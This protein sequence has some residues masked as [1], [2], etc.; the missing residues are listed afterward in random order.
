NAWRSNTMQAMDSAA[1]V[2]DY[3]KTSTFPSIYAANPV[4]TGVAMTTNAFNSPN[5]DSGNHLF[6]TDFRNNAIEVF[7]NQWQDISPGVVQSPNQAFTF[8]TPSTV[9][10]LHPFN[11]QDIGGHLFV[12]YAKFNPASDEGFEDTPGFGHIVE[13][14]ENGTLAKD[15][16]TGGSP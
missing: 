8:Q 12:A 9:Q 11:I 6:A 15:F 7:N 5:Y 4:Y 13:Y 1:L 16:D 14:N 10:D 3:S 2:I